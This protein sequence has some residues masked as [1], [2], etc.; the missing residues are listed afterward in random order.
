MHDLPLR[1]YRP[2]PMVRRTRTELPPRPPAPMIDAHNHLGR[3]LTGEWTVPDVSALLAM[4]D[5]LSLEAFV[6]LDGMWGDELDANLDRYDR[7]HPGR[8]ATFAQWDRRW[9]ELGAWDELAAQLRDAFARGAKGLKVWKDLGLHLR[10]EQGVLV[11]PDDERLDPTWDAVAEAGVPV[12]IHVADPVAFFQPMDERNERLEELLVNPDW[13]FGDRDRFPPFERIVE[14]LEALVARRRDVAWIGAHVLCHAEDTTWVGR[15]LDTY[16]N[17]HADVGARLAELGR[18]PR[19][20]RDLL[21]THTDRFLLGTDSFPPTPAEFEVHRRFFETA[22]EAFPYD[23]DPHDAPSQ[24]RWT[25]SGV[26]LPA[27]V[28]E[29][30]YAGNARR[31][32]FEAAS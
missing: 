14:S 26:D 29:Q 30:L 2:I 1:D 8:F 12:T 11:M 17:V 5:E 3:W 31:L 25:I 23:A 18:V 6:N 16:T 13:W 27:D 19:A 21:A 4:M 10:D 24:G 22:D 9:F 32:I 28:L 15:M 7:A 20:A